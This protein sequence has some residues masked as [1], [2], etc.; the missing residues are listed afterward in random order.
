MHSTALHKYKESTIKYYVTYLGCVEI[1]SRQL[2]ILLVLF[3]FKC[4]SPWWSKVL[5]GFLTHDNI[6]SPSDI[7]WMSYVRLNNYDS[8]GNTHDTNEQIGQTIDDLQ[9]RA[10]RDK[11]ISRST[12]VTIFRFQIIFSS[13]FCATLLSQ[14]KPLLFLRFN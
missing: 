5:C 2:G 14:S 13:K 11:M 12:F 1:T 7:Y 9:V 4:N 8:F 10:W 3:K 6:T